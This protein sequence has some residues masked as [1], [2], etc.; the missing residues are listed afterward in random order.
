VRFEPELAKGDPV[1]PRPR[2]KRTTPKQGG[3]KSTLDRLQLTARLLVKHLQRALAHAKAL[4]GAIARAER[5]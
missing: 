2:I 3:S 1:T 4:E 5:R